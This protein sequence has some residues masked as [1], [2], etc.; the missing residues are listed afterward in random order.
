MI[1]LDKHSAPLGAAEQFGLDLLLD[2]SR[3]LRADAVADAVRLRVVAGDPVSLHACRAQGWCI[4]RQDGCLTI[5]TGVLRLVTS[6]SSGEAEQRAPV[7]DRFGRV[8]PSANALVELGI[9][10]VPVVSHAAVALRNAAADVAGRRPF[11]VLAPW[12]EG[13]RWAVALS[14]DLDVVDHWP[15]FTGLRLAELVRKGDFRRAASVG[16][17][18]IRTVARNPVWHG[19]RE[20]LDTEQDIGAL[21]T[22][23]V[24]C[25][26]PTLATMRAG[27]LTYRIDSAL[28]RR[29]LAAVSSGG[30]E[31]GLHGSFATYTNLEVFRAQREHLGRAL[32]RVPRGVRQHYLRMQPGETQTAMAG[33]GFDYDSTFGFADRNGFRL[34]VADILPAWNAIDQTGAGIDEV[35]FAWMD[36]ALSKYRN[37]EAP[38][39]WIDDAMSLA[40]ECRNV[41]GLWV[42][43]WHPNLTPA[44]GFP[45]APA[46][47]RKLV[48]ALAAGGP[49]FGQMS[50]LVA[51]RRARRSARATAILSDASVS[52]FAPGAT[53][54]PLLLEDGH[55]RQTGEGVQIAD[56]A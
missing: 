16:I 22:W 17:A 11:R 10:R 47:Y 38:E 41:D 15:A 39:A 19:V 9:E 29:I 21:S 7:R 23:F 42:G 8:P 46:A 24:L 6:I 12:P 31:I 28:A 37:V 18:A 54:H 13:R 45:G 32:K 36:R 44:L 50:D 25:G 48:G 3:L 5:P 43:V 56:R 4:E 40:T 14:H 49:Y 53:A 55:G 52:A 34:G 51:W 2:L 27:D 35:P 20:L 1:A 26:T 33:A 30:H